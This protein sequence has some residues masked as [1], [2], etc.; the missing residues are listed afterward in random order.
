M[1]T[2]GNITLLVHKQG[3]DFATAHWEHDRATVL[4][5]FTQS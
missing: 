3:Y 4:I 5:Q 1:R 2:V